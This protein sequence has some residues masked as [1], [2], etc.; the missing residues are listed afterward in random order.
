[1]CN[2]SNIPS[3]QKLSGI[4]WDEFIKLMDCIVNQSS[5]SASCWQYNCIV[6]YLFNWLS[7]Y[8]LREYKSVC[9]HC[10]QHSRRRSSSESS[11]SSSSSESSSG[12]EE[13]R[14]SRRS[15]S[16]S[17]RSKKEKKHKSKT[18]RSSTSVIEDA[19]GPVALSRFFE[20]VKS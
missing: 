20:N 9:F 11:H 14:E 16:K 1:M 13:E 5:C 17:R 8:Q 2:P 3:Y 19:D 15:K 7:K 12:D 6:C 10:V 4:R 18:K